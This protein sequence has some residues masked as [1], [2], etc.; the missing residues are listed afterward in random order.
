MLEEV[1]RKLKENSNTEPSFLPVCLSTIDNTAES[2]DF[3]LTKGSEPLSNFLQFDK[4]LKLC[5]VKREE[6]KFYKDKR[7]S[8]EDPSI[9]DFEFIKTLGKGGF[10]TVYMGRY[11]SRSNNF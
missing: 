4:K 3:F 2:V 10:A 5:Y 7:V 9:T 11:N 8:V 6:I 1:L